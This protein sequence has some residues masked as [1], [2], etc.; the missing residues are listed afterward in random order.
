MANREWAKAMNKAVFPGTQG[1]P[2]EHIIA[3]K[4]VAFGEALR[5]DFKVYIQG[6]LDN[7]K[8]MAERLK[9]HG[10]K[11]VS[12]GTD[13]H[14]MLVDLGDMCSGKDAEDALG[15][16]AI[17]VNKN[18]V[19]GEKR[20]PFVTSGVRIGTPAMTTRGMGVEESTQ[21][22][23]WISEAITHRDDEN[24]LKQIHEDMRELCNRF[25]VYPAELMD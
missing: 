2:L 3:A 9:S 11:L 4:A 15:K 6:V 12:G 23:D 25:P 24:R 5:P 13:N 18:T 1:G 16:A 14:L 21:I 10:F 7:A 22:A 19:P 20:S 8:A 17:T